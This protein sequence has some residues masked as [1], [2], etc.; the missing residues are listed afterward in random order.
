MKKWLNRLLF[1]VV[2]L[3]LLLLCFIVLNYFLISISNRNNIHTELSRLGN[4]H[5]VLILGA[6]NS[7]LG[8]WQNTTF[9]NRMNACVKLNSKNK[10]QRIVCSGKI[11]RPYYNEPEDMNDFLLKKGIPSKLIVSDNYGTST[12]RSILNYA[13]KYEGDS[14]IIISQRLHLERALF[15]AKKMGLHP[16]G[17]SAGEYKTMNYKFYLYEAL[18][19][20]KV[21]WELLIY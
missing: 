12:F 14:V 21:Q 19:R 2:I 16:I 17:Y 3:P 11:K 10:L 1:L 5:N 13:N 18:A 7:P 4:Y 6:G 8:E 15:V 9:S 20:M